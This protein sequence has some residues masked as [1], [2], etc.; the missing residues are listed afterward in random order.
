M[1]G[2]SGSY[3]DKWRELLPLLALG[4][5]L[6]EE[7]AG[8]RDHLEGCAVCRR[9]LGEIEEAL[10]LLPSALAPVAP[11]PALRERLLRRV[12]DEATGVPLSPVVAVPPRPRS[13]GQ[14]SAAAPAAASERGAAQRHG[15]GGSYL[16]LSA[17]LCAALSAGGL[18]L[19]EHRRLQALRKERVA[20]LDRL[21]QA[22]E[23]G[24]QSE[25]RLAEQ[26][27]SLQYLRARSMQVVTLKSPH[28]G[29]EAAAGTA[30]GRILWDQDHRAWLFV[31]FQLPPPPPDKDYQ[32]WFLTRGPEGETVPVS[33]G[34]VSV[35]PTGELEAD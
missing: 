1:S 31:A 7:A 5:P 9:E 6:G 21:R 2:Y 14:G 10:T 33:A 25:Q 22:R 32:L 11:D 18:Y 26:E 20:L 34:L 23:Q 12:R 30:L 29:G 28:K 4:S 35:L 19:R 15:R 16:L 3:C 27:K 13:Q 8:L 17:S 24:G